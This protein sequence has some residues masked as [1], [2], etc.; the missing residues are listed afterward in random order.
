MD[1]GNLTTA[2]ERRP[3]VGWLGLFRFA[4]SR[5]GASG[6]LRLAPASARKRFPRPILCISWSRGH[7]LLRLPG[8]SSRHGDAH[9]SDSR[10]CVWFWRLGLR[11]RVLGGVYKICYDPTWGRFFKDLYASFAEAITNTYPTRPLPDIFAIGA[12]RQRTVKSRSYYSYDVGPWHIIAL[13][14][15]CEVAGLGGCGDGSPQETWLRQGPC[16]TS[17]RACTIAYGHHPLFSSGLLKAARKSPGTAQILGGPVCRA[18][19]SDARRA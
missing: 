4:W 2:L 12:T 7:R 19:G 9:R 8:R 16:R 11:A 13:N 17:R 6:T 5:C 1:V 3:L 10:H 18:R 15:N 14:T